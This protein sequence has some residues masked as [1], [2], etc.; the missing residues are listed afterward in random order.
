LA[1]TNT[2]NIPFW[3]DMVVVA[4]FS[5]AIFYW[6]QFTKLPRAEMLDLVGRQSAAPADELPDVPRH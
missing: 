5:L 3:W 2:F 4:A 1:P 6:A